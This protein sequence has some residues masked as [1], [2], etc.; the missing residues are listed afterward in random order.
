MTKTTLQH[1]GEDLFAIQ[2]ALFVD[3]P[4]ASAR[5]GLGIGREQEITAAF[6]RGYDAWV[7][8]ATALVDEASRSAASYEDNGAFDFLTT[9]ILRWQRLGNALAGTVFTGLWQ[10]LGVATAA[11][12]HSL[13]AEMQAL[14]EEL[15]FSLVGPLPS[16]LLLQ[17]NGPRLPHPPRA[18]E[19]ASQAPSPHLA[20]FAQKDRVATIDWND[21]F[22][23]VSSD[24]P[25][26]ASS[27][28][29][30]HEVGD[31][32]DYFEPVSTTPSGQ[33]ESRREMEAGSEPGLVKLPGRDF[34]P[35]P[36]WMGEPVAQKSAA[37]AKVLR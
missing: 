7:R 35:L 31:W 6:W 3:V 36:H 29:S 18:A 4:L 22:E 8:V 1:I 23:P 5:W 9:W 24:P 26:I 17:G 16:S 34:P 32:N 12:V 33:R 27:E 21:Y 28:E 20:V 10:T 19:A 25:L 14:S 13:H 2:Q 15:R 37:R 11:Q 30:A